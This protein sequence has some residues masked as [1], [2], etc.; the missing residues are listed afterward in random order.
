VHAKST[1]RS[2]G[3]LFRIRFPHLTDNTEAT[4]PW[5]AGEAPFPQTIFFSSSRTKPVQFLQPWRAAPSVTKGYASLNNI[6]LAQG[7]S[8][9]AP[10][11][12]PQ[13]G[14]RGPLVVP[15]HE[16]PTW[17]YFEGVYPENNSLFPQTAIIAAVINTF[18]ETCD[19][20]YTV[21]HHLGRLGPCVA[22]QCP[23]RMRWVKSQDWKG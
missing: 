1:W 16:E 15:T 3:H 5:G 19:G 22:V 14:R 11:P 4:L 10:P 6:D 7:A 2:L 13:G 8:F 17:K 20:V 9:S 23:S 18:K 12:P 21:P